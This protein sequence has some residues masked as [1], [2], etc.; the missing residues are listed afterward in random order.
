[1]SKLVPPPLPPVEEFLP[2]IEEQAR[3][4][5]QHLLDPDNPVDLPPAFRRWLEGKESA[6]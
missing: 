2:Q 5:L 6:A 1:M 3:R 4:D